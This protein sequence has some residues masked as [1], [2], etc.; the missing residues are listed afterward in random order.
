MNTNILVYCTFSYDK[1]NLKP[2]SL[3]LILLSGVT[4]VL[5]RRRMKHVVL[6]SGL[7]KYA[8]RQAS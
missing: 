8:V 6:E 3:N 7:K 5:M 2:F 1:K 4:C